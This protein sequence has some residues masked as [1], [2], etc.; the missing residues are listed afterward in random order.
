MQIVSSNIATRKPITW[1]GKTWETGIFKKEINQAIFL[2]KTGVKSD[3]VVDLKHH[4]GK[5]KAVYAFSKSHYPFFKKQFPKINFYNGIFGENLTVDNLDEKEIYIGDV[6]R[7]GEALIQVSQPRLPC[8]TL[9]AVFQSDLMM[10]LFINTT[11]SGVYFSVLKEG[12][13]QPNGS[14]ELVDQN[15]EALTVATVYSLFTSNKTNQS[16]IIKA[17]DLEALSPSLKQD[18]QRKLLI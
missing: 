12:F 16:L 3:A 2:T 17:L 5:D 4:G 7:V 9:N 15:K 8:K 13:L 10:K 18:I 1:K 14:F 11:F 6:F